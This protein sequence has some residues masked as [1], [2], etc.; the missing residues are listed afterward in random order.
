MDDDDALGTVLRQHAERLTEGLTDPTAVADVI[1]RRARARRHRWTAATAGLA[2]AAA[3]A[4]V[5]V[6][7]SATGDQATVRTPAVSPTLGPTIAP[8]TVPATT[9]TPTTPPAPTTA[10]PATIAPATIA[11][12]TVPAS[13]ATLPA[14]TATLAPVSVPPSTV[15]T[16]TYQGV[17]G[18]IRVRLTGGTVMLAADPSPVPGYTTRI[19][20]N[21]PARVRV[22]FERDDERTEIRVD[23]ED[24]R[25]VPT[26]DE[27]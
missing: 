3:V 24:G 18:S 26:I 15:T 21:G 2:T 20:D 6:V 9:P 4:G 5:L 16:A 27:D 23:V 14:S 10:T 1:A 8:S 7:A 19:D 25:L 13:T 12:T 11:P 17:G 22:R